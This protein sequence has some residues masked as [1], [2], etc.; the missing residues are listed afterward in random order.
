MIFVLKKNPDQMVSIDKHD[1]DGSPQGRRQQR[2]AVSQPKMS[3]HVLE[4]ML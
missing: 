2:Y 3:D 4:E 1:H